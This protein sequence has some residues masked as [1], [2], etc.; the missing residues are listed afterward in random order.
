MGVGFPATST[1]FPQAG[2]PAVIVERP[3]PWLW[4]VLAFVVGRN[5]K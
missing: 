1:T 4:L 2:A 3:F 5:W